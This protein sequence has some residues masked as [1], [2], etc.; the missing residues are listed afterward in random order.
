MKKEKKKVVEKNKDGRLVSLDPRIQ[1]L[2]DEADNPKRDMRVL[3]AL[4]YDTQEQF[5]RR[6]RREFCNP[7][8]RGAGMVFMYHELEKMFNGFYSDDEVKRKLE[9]LKNHGST[10]SKVNGD[11]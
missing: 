5:E 10:E 3:R 9:N 8:Y 1:E 4:G 6:L 2:L 11:D 7:G